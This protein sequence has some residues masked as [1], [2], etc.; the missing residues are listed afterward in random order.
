MSGHGAGRTDRAGQGGR[1]LPEVVLCDIGL[2]GEMNGYGVSRSLRSMP[3]S[4]SAYLVAVTGYGHEEARRMA[5]E[6]GFDY[7]LTKPVGQRATPRPDDPNAAVLNDLAG[8]QPEARLF[9]SRPAGLMTAM[10]RRRRQARLA[11]SPAGAARSASLA[12]P[13]VSKM[14]ASSRLRM[15]CQNALLERQFGSIADAVAGFRPWEPINAESA[16]H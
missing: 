9:V 5:K 6:A 16:S 2:V 11:E 10:L 1:V 15:P 4:A 12:N 7:H 14:L 3:T 13:E 8:S